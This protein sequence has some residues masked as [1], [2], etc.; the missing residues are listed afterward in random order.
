MQVV[1]HICMY[2]WH[3][4]SN[5]NTWNIPCWL[6]MTVS[7]LMLSW[8]GLYTFLPLLQQ[9]ATP[10]SPPLHPPEAQWILGV[11]SAPVHIVPMR[12]KRTRQGTRLNKKKVASEDRLTLLAQLHKWGLYTIQWCATARRQTEEAAWRLTVMCSAILNMEIC[13]VRQK[14]VEMH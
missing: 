7:I 13:S 8:Q 4:L 6:L 10:C 11:P 5:S 9:T 1:L 14:Q 2:Q 12:K 3:T